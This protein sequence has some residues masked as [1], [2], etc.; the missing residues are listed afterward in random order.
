MRPPSHGLPRPNRGWSRRLVRIVW[1]VA[2]AQI[3]LIVMDPG[4][5]RGRLGPV[6]LAVSLASLLLLAAA[7]RRITHQPQP[8]PAA[9]AGRND[10]PADA[11][12]TAVALGGPCDGASWQLGPDQDP[13]PRQVWLHANGGS[14]RYR[15]DSRPLTVAPTS[16]ATLTYSHH[17]TS[18]TDT[19]PS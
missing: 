10:V 7:A 11:V 3:L 9:E 12:V 4:G 2:V 15:L 1:A 8:L 5:L 19:R 14:H 6:L 17:T 18:T 13:A 16:P